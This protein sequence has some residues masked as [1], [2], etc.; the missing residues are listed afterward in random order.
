VLGLVGAFATGQLIRSLLVDTSPTD[1]ITFVS[2][3]TA[4]A[5]VAGAACLVP[6]RHAMR[7]NPVTA[8]R[9]E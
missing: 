1:P 4:M 5:A 6:L 7:L 3:V 8:L 2:V 9:R